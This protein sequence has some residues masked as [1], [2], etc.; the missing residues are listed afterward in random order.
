M[1][2]SSHIR[3][4]LRGQALFLALL[5]ILFFA[6]VFRASVPALP[7]MVLQLAS[8][9]LLGLL[10]WAPGRL[11]LRSWEW[12]GVGL[13][14]VFPLLYLIPLP[15]GLIEGVPGQAPYRTAMNLVAGEEQPGASPLSLVAYLTQA[16]WLVL[17]VPVAVFIATRQMGET[18]QLSWPWCSMAPLRAGCCCLVSTPRRAARRAL[19]AI[20]TISRACWR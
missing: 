20:A 17:L 10:A 3:H 6:P 11:R 16:S 7:L 1:E 13:L 14:L 9:A 18:Q 19:I 15:G 12:F 4:S 8:V 2:D 5:A